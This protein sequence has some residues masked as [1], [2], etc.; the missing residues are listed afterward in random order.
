MTYIF[1]T[2]SHDGNLILIQ[3]Q[4]GDKEKD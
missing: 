3:L 1:I 4:E 2:M